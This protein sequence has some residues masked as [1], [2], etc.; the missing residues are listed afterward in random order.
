MEIKSDLYDFYSDDMLKAEIPQEKTFVSI[1]I[2]DEWDMRKILP[3]LREKRW[4]NVYIVLNDASEKFMSS[5][6][7]PDFRSV[8][9]ENT[10]IFASTQE[11]QEF[12]K[13]DASAYLPRKVISASD[14]DYKALIREIH[15]ERI[16]EKQC[17]NRIFLSICIPSFNRG[18]RALQAV[19]HALRIEY[20]AEIEI[21]V[22]NNGSTIGKNEYRQI[23]EIEDSRIQYYEFDENKGYAANICRCLEVARGQFAVLFSDEDYLNIENLGAALD[24]LE[25]TSDL[26]YCYFQSTDHEIEEK[27][28]KIY[29][30]GLEAVIQAYKASYFTGNCYNMNYLKE[31]DLCNRVK[32]FYNNQYFKDY[33]Q[34]AFAILLSEQH[35]LEM[36]GIE[37]WRAGETALTHD[38]GTEKG[39]LFSVYMPERRLQ[40][41]RGNMEFAKATF[42]KGDDLKKIFFLR[43][44]DYFYYMALYYNMRGA[45]MKELYSWLDIWLLH[46]KNCMEILKDV[47]QSESPQ[48]VQ[49]MDEI[50][51]YWLNCKMIQGW[52]TPEENLKTNLQVVLIEYYYREKNSVLEIN[53]DE[54]AQKVQRLL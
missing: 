9:P 32:P 37:L 26:G 27:D 23:Q 10:Y 21:I 6:K 34:C 2:A 30:K 14:V 54:I 7:L 11:M 42:L 13:K 43:I 8:F 18:D 29:E 3:I 52:F 41:E 5:F 24:Y 16:K 38:W 46:Y 4:K 39:N 44:R 22:S 25:A 49:E 36:I 17:A 47:M 51:F 31:M 20:D 19:R 45:Q 40:Q 28:I 50:F 48:V 35:N 12:F 33:A 1:L 15:S 53:Y